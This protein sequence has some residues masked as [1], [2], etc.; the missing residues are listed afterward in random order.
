MRILVTGGA[1]FIGTNLCLAARKKGI[2]VLG[3]DNLSKRSSTK[4]L[5]LLTK[6]GV[7]FIRADLRKPLQSLGNVDTI[8]H[9][10]AHCST[11]RSFRKPVSDFLDNALGTLNVLEYARKRGK[12]PV[13]Y[14]ST[15]K[16]YSD[17]VNRLPIKATRTRYTLLKEKTIDER[18]P[19]EPGS[20]SP[21]GCSKYA[22]DLYCQEYWQ[23]FG[24]PTVVN[25]LSTVFGPHQ[26]GSEEAGWIF[27]FV[28]SKKQSQPVTVFGTGKQVR[29]ALWVDDL[30]GLLLKQIDKIEKVKGNVYNVGGGN[31]NSL[32]LL[33]LIDRLNRKGGKPLAVKFDK[34]RRSDLKVF[35]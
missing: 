14:A 21:Y 17:T 6:A 29:D 28:N 26:H 9:L 12:I 33:E 35:I 11:P 25:R 34:T 5:P 10:A 7:R 24:V 27:H 15:I 22:G 3:I 19:I 32:S 4:N 18:F 13:I 20:H 1:G 8:I 23:S 30:T 31:K 16:V 2:K